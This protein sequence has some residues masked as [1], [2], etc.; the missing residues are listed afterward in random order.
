MAAV[1]AGLDI[2]SGECHVV[3]K[4]SAGDVVVDRRF[5]TTE[6]ELRQVA[7]EI[8]LEATVHTEA[9]ELAGWV[10]RIL[11]PLV[12]GVV[13]SDTRTNAWIARDPHKGD[14]VD[15]DK[16]ADLLRLGNFREV[17]YPD[18]ETR[19]QFK[20]VVRLYD[21][22][23]RAQTRIKCQVKS[24]LRQA[25]VIVKDDSAYSVEDREKLL[26]ESPKIVR[27]MV[28]RLGTLLDAT[29]VQQ[30]SARKLVVR[31]SRRFPE[32][33]RLR[34]VPG[35]GPIGASRFVSYIHDPFRFPNKRKLWRYCRLGVT[36]RSSGDRELGHR[37]LDKAG[38]GTLKDVS[39]KAFQGAM[40][41]TKSNAIRRFFEA[42]LERTGSEVHARLSTQRKVLTILWT[43]WKG[44]TS[45][46][47]DY[48]SQKG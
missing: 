1:Y 22:L 48:E 33:A 30:E 13:V 7:G 5:R 40:K 42:S 34:E 8:G 21:D 28:Q 12:K 15:A 11:K 16:L 10:R 35:V 26:R 46:R 47:D 45:Y 27:E 43:L 17:Y 32:I 3:G 4:T 14:R 20:R 41:T 36:H 24:W 2:G 29:V 6:S 9:G 37:H 31:E 44:G 23:T 25:G 38:N 19:S 39:R 18:D